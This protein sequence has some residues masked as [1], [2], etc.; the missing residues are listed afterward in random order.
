MALP[1]NPPISL[2]QVK[3]EFGGSGRLGDYLR[4]GPYVPN[5]PANL[6]VPASLPITLHQLCGATAAVPNPLSIT[7]SRY[8]ASAAGSA[9]TLTTP[10][11]TATVTGGGG[12][13]TYIWE[14][15]GSAGGITAV[16]STSQTTTFRG[17]VPPDRSASFRCRATRSGF[18]V[19]SDPVSVSLTEQ[20]GPPEMTVTLSTYNEEQTV[21]GGGTRYTQV[22][23][24]FVA[25]APGAVAY[26]WSSSGGLSPEF[27]N[28]QSTRYK[29]VIPPNRSGSIRVKVTSGAVTKYSDWCYVQL[30]AEPPPPL[31][32][33]AA[34]TVVFG[35]AAPGNTA[36]SQPSSVSTVGGGSGMT[37]YLWQRVSGDTGIT[38]NGGTTATATFS[39]VV[40]GSPRTAVWRCR[41][42]R[43]GETVYTNNVSITL[44]PLL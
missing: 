39:A 30:N 20:A 28:G 24:A 9:G 16:S 18:Q 5:I 33:Q 29:A 21:T 38:V 15:V 37:T 40:S 23:H 3:A 13:T 22:I 35:I 25:D 12:G 11:V 2:A 7:L 42:Q 31:Q 1:S 41:V 10:S 19:V 17:I 43:D 27:P 4:G 6:G 44:E 34:P 8:S 36:T 32:A 26:E 14:A